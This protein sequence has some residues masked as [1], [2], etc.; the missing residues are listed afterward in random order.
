MPSKKATIEFN[1]NTCVLKGQDKLFC[2]E[3]QMYAEL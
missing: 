3:V 1:V 2:N